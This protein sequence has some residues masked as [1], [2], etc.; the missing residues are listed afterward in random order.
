MTASTI[1]L[2][3]REAST[4]VVRF[5]RTFVRPHAGQWLTICMLMVIGVLLQLTIPMVT[6]RVVDRVIPF[7]NLE[8]L[9]QVILLLVICVAARYAG[10]FANELMTMYLKEKIILS[11]QL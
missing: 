4:P 3:P 2:A 1:A 11:V 5:I 8:A 7:A 6:I 10:N 9:K